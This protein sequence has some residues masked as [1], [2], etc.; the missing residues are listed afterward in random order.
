MFNSI[1][2]KFIL[3][4]LLFYFN[5]NSAGTTICWEKLFSKNALIENERILEFSGKIKNFTSIVNFNPPIYK[6]RQHYEIK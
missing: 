5:A 2:F 1:F 6:L 3:F 4:L